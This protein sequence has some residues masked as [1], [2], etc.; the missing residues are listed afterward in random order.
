MSVARRYPGDV[1]PELSYRGCFTCYE[2][3]RNAVAEI[4]DR[5]FLGHRPIDSEVSVC[6]NMRQLAAGSPA[7]TPPHARLTHAC[8]LLLVQGNAGPY[9]FQSYGE[10]ARR[11]DN[12]FSGQLSYLGGGWLA[13]SS[14]RS[15]PLTSV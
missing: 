12:F 4:P 2:L 10:V 11:V 8:G 6:L 5:P 15:T 14:P 9:V 7:L 1:G 3:F 13:P